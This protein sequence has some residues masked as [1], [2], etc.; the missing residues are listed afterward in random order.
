MPEIKVFEVGRSVAAV[1]LEP[2]WTARRRERLFAL[3]CVAP[4]ALLV[5]GLI[6][7]PALFTMWL[8]LQRRELFAHSGT[9][10]CRRR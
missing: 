6:L 10:W 3:A 4:T 2:R 5:A 9:T 7:Y 1:R 8:S